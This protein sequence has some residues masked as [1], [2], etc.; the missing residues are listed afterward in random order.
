MIFAGRLFAG[1]AED[2]MTPTFDAYE[3]VLDAT[4]PAIVLYAKGG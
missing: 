2:G 1:L 4:R 3:L